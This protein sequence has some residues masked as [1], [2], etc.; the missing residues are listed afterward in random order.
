[1]VDLKA[2]RLNFEKTKR[3]YDS[4]RGDR[5]N[6]WYWSFKLT[7]SWTVPSVQPFRFWNKSKQNSI[8][9]NPVYYSKSLL[10]H[11]TSD[12]AL[13]HR[14]ADILNHIPFVIEEGYHKVSLR[15]HGEY[16]KCDK[17]NMAL[18]SIKQSEDNNDSFIVRLNEISG[19]EC[20]AHITCDTVG[21]DADI[22]FTPY[23]IVT[24][25]ISD[26]QITSVNFTS[27]CV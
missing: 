7:Q 20:L 14:C 25:K 4:T 27:V 21:L 12:R 3:I 2:K 11:E 17:K 23:Q 8:S 18:L 5:R 22:A 1:M 6:D 10:P 19:K 26:G 16:F 9:W 13:P 24:L 15:Q